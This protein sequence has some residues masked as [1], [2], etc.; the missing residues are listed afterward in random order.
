M[1]MIEGKTAWAEIPSLTRKILDPS[2]REES[3]L[4]HFKKGAQGMRGKLQK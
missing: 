3:T 4:K 1:R 2:A